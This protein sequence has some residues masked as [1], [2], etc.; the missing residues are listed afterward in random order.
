MELIYKDITGQKFGR[1]TAKEIVGKTK[2]GARIWRCDCD[3]GGITNVVINNLT[4]GHTKSCGCLQKE[5]R[6]THGLSK[7]K[8][9]RIYYDMIQRCSNKD[10][11]EYE[12]Y[13]GRN[14]RVCDEWSGENGFVNFYNWSIKNNYKE[15]LTID[16]IKVD[17][18]Y[19]PEN[20]RW[21]TMKTQQNNRRNNNYIT[22]NEQVHT[23]TEWNEILGFKRGVLQSRLSRGWDIDRAFTEPSGYIKPGYNKYSYRNKK[24]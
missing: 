6:F 5:V 18:N 3:C 8:I 19:C 2:H 21:A 10:F 22:Y 16:R 7:T 20:C 1:L 14:I 11:K 23:L 12:H 17:G 15:G 13:G 24:N 9:Y 4:N